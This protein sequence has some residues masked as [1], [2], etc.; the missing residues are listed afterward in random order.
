MKLKLM[1]LGILIDYA[2]MSLQE[3]SY[4][5]KFVERDLRHQIFPTQY[6]LL[7]PYSGCTGSHVVLVKRTIVSKVGGVGLHS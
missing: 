6:S 7:F 1:M 2:T 3:N 4:G 5:A